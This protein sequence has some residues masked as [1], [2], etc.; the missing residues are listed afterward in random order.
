[1]LSGRRCVRHEAGQVAVFFALL[2]PIM[3]GLAAVVMDVGNWFVHKRH[4][5]TQVDAAALAA[6]PQFVGCFLDPTS[7]NQAI[8]SR[9]LAYAGDTLR[10]GK[11]SSGAPDSTTNTQVQQPDDVRIALNANRYWQPSDGMVPG[12]DG[13][14]LD[15]TL[16]SADADTFGD[17]CNER[18]LDV[19]ATDEDAPPLWGLIPLTPSP[20]SKARVEIH[21][22]ESA[23]G[24]LPWAVPE[25]DPA[26]VVALFV[27][28]DPTGAEPEIFKTQDLVEFDNAS[29]PWSEWITAGGQEEV[30]LDSGHENTGIVILISKNDDT[31]PLSSDLSDTCT[32]SPGL[33]ACYGNPTGLTS[34]LSFI[35]AYNGGDTGDLQTPIAREVTLTDVGCPPGDDSAP[36]FT[37]SGGCSAGISAVVDFG[38]TGATDPGDWPN[39]VKVT[40]SPGGTMTWAGNVVGGSLFTGTSMTLATASGRAPNLVDISWESEDNPGGPVRRGHRI[41]AGEVSPALR[42]QGRR[43]PS[44]GDQPELGREELRRQQLLLQGRGRTAEAACDRQLP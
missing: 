14:G 34:G 3:F 40:S 39:C 27:D 37:L 7:A 38:V 17:P 33:I 12:T 9:A 31:P 26:A 23:S 2:I 4:L 5:Q 15:N 44:A 32:S 11:I 35:K 19:K 43:R 28:E 10:P 18:Y 36:Y 16:D 6:G 20:K 25:I 8:A 41:R 29:Y 13:Y 42:H 30:E 1:M 21:D 24:V 22:L